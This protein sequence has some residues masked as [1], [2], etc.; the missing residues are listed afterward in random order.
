[1]FGC[2]ISLR[3]EEDFLHDVEPNIV[4]AGGPARRVPEGAFP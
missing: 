4:P 3:I 2:E 1:M